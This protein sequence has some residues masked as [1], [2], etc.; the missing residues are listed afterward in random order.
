LLKSREA[1]TGLKIIAKRRNT[2]N[3]NWSK[4]SYRRNLIDMHITD[5]KEEFLSKLDPKNYVDTVVT[6]NVNAIMLYANSHI[7]YCFFPTKSGAM[8]PNLKGRDFLGESLDYATKKGLATIVYYSLMVNRWAAGNHPDWG[9]KKVNG[10]DLYLWGLPRYKTC[11]INNPGYREFTKLELTD[12]CE[13]YSFDG[14]WMDFAFW[15]GVCYCPTCQERYL[16]ETGKDLP[17]NVDWTDPEWIQFQR[18]REAWLVEFA[19]FTA[20][21]VKGCKPDVT[22]AHQSALLTEG[23]GSGASTD[24][25]RTYDYLSADLFCERDYQTFCNKLFYH[26]S[27]SQPFEYMTSRCPSLV[28]HTLTKSEEQLETQTFSAIAKGAAVQFIDA[29]DPI[30]TVQTNA[31]PMMGNVFKKVELIEKYLGGQ[32]VEDV[33]VYHS[34]ESCVPFER[35]G[36]VESYDTVEGGSGVEFLADIRIEGIDVNEFN[37]AHRHTS[38]GIA[39]TLNENHIPYAIITR[40]NLQALSS[41]E[42]L[43]LPEVIYMDKDEIRAVKDYVHNGGNLIATRYTSLYTTDG[44]TTGNFQLSDLFGVDFTGPADDIINYIAP[45]EKGKNLLTPYTRSSPLCIFADYIATITAHE[46]TTVLGTLTKAYSDPFEP[47]NFASIHSNPPGEPTD[48]PVITFN[49]YGRGKVIYLA[50]HPNL[51]YTEMQTVFMNLVHH[52]SD[53]TFSIQTD[54]PKCVEITLFEQA[55]KNRLLVHVLNFQH[56]LP[57]I[58]INNINMQI[59]CENQPAMVLSLPDKNR[60]DFSYTNGYVEF[61]VPELQTYALYSI[62]W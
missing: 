14:F 32:P 31:Y 33:A 56:E 5:V 48:H 49:T 36:D 6:S 10:E 60:L 18:R 28:Y 44:E 24:F 21:T 61:K 43:F 54:A 46:K 41:Y 34:F 23:W 9:M 26:L 19:H 37:S 22:V 47:D 16:K 30:G 4:T 7:G 8:H 25:A 39:K 2:M 42:I 12:I 58:P 59:K 50:G 52:L 51:K 1:E 15:P 11:C 29:I 3:N 40:K 55:G 13:N 38:L 35:K 53:M 27:E 17:R 20:S 57:N 62:D 45:T